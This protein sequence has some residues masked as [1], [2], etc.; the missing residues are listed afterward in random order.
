MGASGPRRQ[1]LPVFRTVRPEQ[2]SAAV[3]LSSLPLLLALP[4]RRSARRRIT[5][6]L[7]SPPIR[8]DRRRI[9]AATEHLTKHRHWVLHRR[10]RL[11]ELP[12]RFWIHVLLH[13]GQAQSE[14]TDR[15][16][17]QQLRIQQEREN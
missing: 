7:A 16:H 2:P 17:K 3:S 12:A 13:L 1:P 5:L 9:P 15:H 4:S 11:L 6:L 8:R 10:L 14:A